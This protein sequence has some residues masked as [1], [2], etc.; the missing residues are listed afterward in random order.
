MGISMSPS[1]VNLQT[2]KVSFGIMHLTK[3]KTILGE[4]S[5][6]VIGTNLGTDKDLSSFG[7][8]P[9]NTKGKLPA[10]DCDNYGNIVLAQSEVDQ[11]SVNS[12]ITENFQ[13][14]SVLGSRKRKAS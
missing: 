2:Q 1:K 4:I 3:D 5:K 13:S 12:Q 14:L 11:D 9:N 10:V 8:E 6:E 7:Y